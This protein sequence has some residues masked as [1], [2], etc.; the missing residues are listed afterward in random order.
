MKRRAFTLVELLVVISIIAL[1][2]SLLVPALG[3]AEKLARTTVCANNMRQLVLGENE[4]AVE[5]NG[6]GTPFTIEGPAGITWADHFWEMLLMPEVNYQSKIFVCPEV[7]LDG[8][9]INNWGSAG[10]TN[11]TPCA[12]AWH[13]TAVS[14]S[15]MYI[16]LNISA[17]CFDAL[18]ARTYCEICGF[19]ITP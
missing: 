18:A 9:V 7:V 11:L 4:Y 16:A 8:N 10:Y 2:V 6:A 14:R 19:A 13:R 17:H 5:W 15:A 1:L 3:E 12:R